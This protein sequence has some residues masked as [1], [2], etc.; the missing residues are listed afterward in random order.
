[1]QFGRVLSH[2]FCSGVIKAKLTLFDVQDN[3]NFESFKKRCGNLL[4]ALSAVPSLMSKT[5]EEL[6][7]A[8]A[9]LRD[10]IAINDFDKLYDLLNMRYLIDPQGSL[11]SIQDKAFDVV[12]SMDVLEHVDHDAFH[13]TV[14][15]IH[16]L[17]KPGGVSIHQIGLDD[18]LTHYVPG[19]PLKNYLRYSTFIWKLFF[20]N[21][22]QY[23][24]RLQLP[25][26]L[27]SFEASGFDLIQSETE[28]DVNLGG[29]HPHP[30]F[31]RFDNNALKAT[32]AY[33]VHRKPI[34]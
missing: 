15:N 23:F 10:I 24:N 28:E 30:E 9:L 8:N 20:E 21:R 25:E 2:T 11:D 32:R 17:L 4:I 27:S 13:S 18:H 6:D 5:A 29:I 3:R 12:F 22:L 33:L 34:S 1:M 26:I 7:I 31:L 16:R 14:Q 19:M